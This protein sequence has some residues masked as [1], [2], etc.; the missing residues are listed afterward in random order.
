MKPKLIVYDFDGVLTDNRVW[1]NEDGVEWVACNRGDGWW[2]GQIR[3]L[4]IEQLILS[5]EKNRV[6]SARGKK[7]SLEVRQGIEDKGS[8]LKIL[9]GEKK[10]TPEDVLYIGNDMNDY[11]CFQ[12]AG[13]SMAPSDSHPRILEIAK[14]VLPEKGGGGIV[15]HLYDWIVSQ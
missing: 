7:L 15:R 12:I 2:I 9:I 11:E 4:G 6:V 13:M 5:T 3:K 14:K 1:L 10:L 8:A